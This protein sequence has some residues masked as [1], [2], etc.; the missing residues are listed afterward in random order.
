MITNTILPK[1]PNMPNAEAQ[2]L[3]V[4]KVK[5]QEKLYYAKWTNNHPDKIL[6]GLIQTPAIRATY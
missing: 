1:R 4:L 5:E 3:D 2:F 6:C